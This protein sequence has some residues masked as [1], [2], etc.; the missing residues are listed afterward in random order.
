MS[1]ST[2]TKTGAGTSAAAAV[3]PATDLP[4]VDIAALK[5]VGTLQQRDKEFFVL[6]LRLVGGDINSELLAAVSEIAR[7]HGRGEIHL[8]TRQGIEI[9]WVHHSQAM[10]ARAALEAAGLK[11]GACGPRCRV[12]VA[13]PGATICRWG[14]IDTKDLAARLDAEFFGQETPHKFKFGVTGCPHNCAK[15]SENDFGVTG[16]ILPAWEAAGCTG[17]N[18]CLGICPTKAIREENGEYLLDEAKCIQ[19]SICTS[20]CPAGSWKRARAGYRVSIGGTMGKIPRLA[21]WIGP[22]TTDVETVL[23]LARAAI[24]WYRANGRKRERF[25]HTIDRLGVE[26]AREEI[27]VAAGLAGERVTGAGSE[28]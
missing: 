20:G 7:V 3:P 2:H 18:L 8:S 4:V 21:T 6:R 5:K 17:C 12:V 22:L 26:H 14:V 25:G 15:A 1:Q 27:L 16:S 19:C 11:M 10:A 23:A 24:A 9:P 13:C 28:N